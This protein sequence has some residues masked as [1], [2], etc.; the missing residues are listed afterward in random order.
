[1]HIIDYQFCNCRGASKL[2]LHNNGSFVAQAGHSH[3]NEDKGSR[4]I[5]QGLRRTTDSYYGRSK[6]ANKP[7]GGFSL[8]Y[9]ML[10]CCGPKRNDVHTDG[11][12]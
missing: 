8:D 12:L 11:P 3:I 9:E 6:G 1:M 2:D 7:A 10:E 4:T 5:R